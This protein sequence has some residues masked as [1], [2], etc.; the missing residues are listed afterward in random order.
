MHDTR[1]NT[2]VTGTRKLIN[3]RALGVNLTVGIVQSLPV[4]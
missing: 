4:D 2:V 1:Q 3:S